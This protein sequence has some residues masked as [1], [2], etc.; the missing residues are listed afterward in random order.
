MKTI[1]I[2]KSFFYSA[3]DQ[4][5]WTRD[6]LDKRGVGVAM[7]EL[8]AHFELEL[9][10]DKV[11]YQLNSK[12]AMAFISKYKSIMIVKGTKIGIVSKTLL[13]EIK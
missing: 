8:F 7:R 9:I 10:I 11:K 6:N 1:K 4:Y 12:E 3:G 5:G 13:E 2:K